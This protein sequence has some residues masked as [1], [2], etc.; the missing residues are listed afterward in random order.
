MATARLDL[1]LD[2][3]IK[4][5]IEKASALSGSKTLTEFIVKVLDET[6]S[7]V[8]AKHETMTLENDIFDRFVE[9]CNNAQKPNKALRD[10]AK[11]TKEHGF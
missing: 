10:A 6:S 7:Q 11:Y 3:N 2:A 8:I 4:N 5:K 9:A 1:R